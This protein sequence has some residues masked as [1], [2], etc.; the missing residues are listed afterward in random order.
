[1]SEN[2]PVNPVVPVKTSREEK[3]KK[4]WRALISYWVLG[5]CNNYGYVVM[6]TAANDLI[7]ETEER[8]KNVER[9][10]SYMSTGAI[11]LADIIPSLL[12]KLI[13]PFL[14]FF[15]KVRIALCVGLCAASFILVAC[16]ENMPTLITGIVATSMSSGL[17]EVTCLQYSSFF[18]KNVVSAWS[19]GTGGAG[20]IG[21]LSYSI[22]Q[23]IGRKT[24][25]FIMLIIPGLM[26]VAF[27][28][29]LPKPQADEEKLDVQRQVN[30]EEIERPKESMKKKIRYVPS[31]FKYMIPFGLVYFLE[32]FINQ[33]TFE[34]INFTNTFLDPSDQYRWLQVVY[35]AG[36]LISRSSVNLFHI[37]HI[38][39]FAVLQAINVVIFTTE[40]IFYYCPSFWIIVTLT[41]WEGLLGG[42][43]YVNTYY[44]ISYEVP[45]ENKQF[46]MAITSF[47]DSIGITL[48]GITAIY[49]HNAICSLP[50]PK[51]PY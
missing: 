1:M 13:A 51:M 17:G 16:G 15:V 23:Y 40:V 35:Q 24:T 46:S 47:S 30:T 26:S 38:W 19:S 44:R 27:F 42:A 21:A 10:C 34:L 20:V 22:L 28:I 4:P 8:K 50:P 18:D 32:Y 29:I 5:L 2:Q 6:L 9:N 31:L 11:L 37:K 49:A 14:P 48:A 45:E 39:I 36:V 12:A 3:E 41:L 33:G 43:A 25:L 7:G